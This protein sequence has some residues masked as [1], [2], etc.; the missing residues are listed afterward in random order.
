MSCYKLCVTKEQLF[1]LSHNFTGRQSSAL[2]SHM[3][4]TE[5]R[6][7]QFA[8]GA[9]DLSQEHINNSHKPVS[10]NDSIENWAKD[11]DRNFTHIA[12]KHG[13]TLKIVSN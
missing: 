10:I 1:T 13:K 11:V 7:S 6:E 9:K 2:L 12:N 3:V 4:L 8:H 5:R